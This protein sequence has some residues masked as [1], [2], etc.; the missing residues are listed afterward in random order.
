MY[1]L[2]ADGRSLS[3][4]PS[5]ESAR[6]AAPAPTR[7]YPMSFQIIERLLLIA[8]AA[9]APGFSIGAMGSADRLGLPAVVGI[10]ALGLATIGVAT[11][12]ARVVWKWIVAKQQLSVGRRALY[13]ALAL[14][15]IYSV[16]FIVMI[17]ILV[18]VVGQ[19]RAP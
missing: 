6:L 1:D 16:A 10:I 17:A 9:A 2:F 7:A 19:S 15:G 11:G 4:G 18:A 8:P 14:G 12:I 3:G 5:L 13:G